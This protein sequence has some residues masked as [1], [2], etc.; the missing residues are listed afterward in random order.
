MDKNKKSLKFVK[1]VC[2]MIILA[3]IVMAAMQF[4]KVIIPNINSKNQTYTEISSYETLRDINEVYPVNIELPL[5]MSETSCKF[6]ITDND[7]LY[8]VG[9]GAEYRVKPI[10]MEDNSLLD[11]YYTDFLDYDYIKIYKDSSDNYIITLEGETNEVIYIESVTDYEYRLKSLSEHS[12]SDLLNAI[13]KN[14]NNFEIVEEYQLKFGICFVNKVFDTY[15]FEMH[16]PVN[17]TF[18]LDDVVT[19]IFNNKILLIVGKIQPLGEDR[20]WAEEV[21]QDIVIR[22]MKESEDDLIKFII[23]S[24][25]EVKAY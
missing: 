11:R 4:V 19:I 12:I 25:V 5:I 2:W 10:N 21:K 6:D 8:I 1:I 9:N 18:A 14:I 15:G 13:S 3:V 22:Y 24:I 20:F 17:A 23:D 7:K 16:I